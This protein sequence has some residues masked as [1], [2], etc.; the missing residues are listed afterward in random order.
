MRL[1]DADA[2]FKTEREEWL[3]TNNAP[4]ISV[5]YATAIKEIDNAPTVCD[6]EQIRAEIE[7]LQIYPCKTDAQSIRN[8]AFEQA[9]AIIDKY[10]G[11]SE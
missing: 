8:V 3:C 1:I 9:L 2:L 11:V 5:D 4:F 10:T 7:H 6:I